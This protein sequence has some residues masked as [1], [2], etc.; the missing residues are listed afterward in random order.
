MGY[1]NK[2]LWSLQALANLEQIIEDIQVRHQADKGLSFGLQFL[3]DQ[4]T[5]KKPGEREALRSKESVAHMKFMCCQP[6]KFKGSE[7]A[8]GLIRWFDSTCDKCFPV[9]IYKDCKGQL[10]SGHVSRIPGMAKPCV[11][12]YGA[13][14][15]E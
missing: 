15:E 1:N 5:T 7:G 4:E 3:Y 8:V 12:F 13:D 11:T 9:A 10:I 6:I 2:L 14:S